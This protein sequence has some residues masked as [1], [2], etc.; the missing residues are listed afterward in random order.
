MDRCIL[1]SVSDKVV[2]NGCLESKAKLVVLVGI[3]ERCDDGYL[4][5]VV[6]D[7]RLVEDDGVPGSIPFRCLETR[8]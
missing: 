6:D 1:D 7:S 2:L 5:S 8:C 4:Q 3:Q